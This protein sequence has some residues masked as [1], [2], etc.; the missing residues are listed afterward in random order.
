MKRRAKAEPKDAGIYT[1]TVD[2][3]P[4]GPE[5]WRQDAAIIASWLNNGGL[6]EILKR[7][8]EMMEDEK[9]RT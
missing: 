6:A 7:N 4:T 2:G 5:V 3:S 1:I 9:L 8:D